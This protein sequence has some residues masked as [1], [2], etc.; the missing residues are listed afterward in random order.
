MIAATA[1]AMKH[2]GIEG[3][4]FAILLPDSADAPY[5][6]YAFG[7]WSI[8]LNKEEKNESNDS[9]LDP[10]KYIGHD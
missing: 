1:A 4:I 7:I 6:I 3:T 5:Q 9:P 10:T 2:F 8:F